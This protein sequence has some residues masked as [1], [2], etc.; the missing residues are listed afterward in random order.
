MSSAFKLIPQYTYD[1]YCLWEGQWELIEGIPFAMSPAP[2]PE[3]QRVAG[4]LHAEFR[5]A[6]KKSGCHC[7][8]YQPIDYKISEETV[9][10]PDLMIVCKPISKAFL[11]FPP[12]VVVEILSKATQFKD[13]NTKFNFY[14][15][16]G[17]PYYLLVDVEKQAAE[18]Y[19]LDDEKKYATQEVELN[20]PFRFNLSDCGFEITF[21]DIWE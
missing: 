20:N 13:R 14:E 3:H 1:D 4:N 12:E 7:Q 5:M 8:V 9:F 19:K 6:L 2:M 15:K 10:N 17:I 21:S 18:I 11:D 16:E